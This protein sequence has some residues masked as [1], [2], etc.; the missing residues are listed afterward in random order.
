MSN[1]SISIP[2]GMIFKTFY[3]H[4]CGKKLVKKPETRTVRPGSPDYHKHAK[5]R[6][7]HMVGDIEVTEY[8]FRCPNCENTVEYDEQCVIASVQKKLCRKKLSDEEIE[9]NRFEAENAIALKK[10][11]TGAIVFA[12]ALIAFFLMWYFGAKS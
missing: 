10:K 1:Q 8:H 6:R 7:F 2:A 4:K 3:C 9:H 5:S 12:V 11:I